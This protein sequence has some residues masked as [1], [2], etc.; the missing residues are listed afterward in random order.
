MDRCRGR[1]QRPWPHPSRGRI[2]VLGEV[3]KRDEWDCLVALAVA[4]LNLA[5]NGRMP[6]VLDA[7][8]EWSAPMDGSPPVL[9]ALLAFILT[10]R[11]RSW[12]RLAR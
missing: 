6:E 4:V 7:L 10:A 5:E 12:T 9:K 2:S 3:L 8:L 1:G 11:T